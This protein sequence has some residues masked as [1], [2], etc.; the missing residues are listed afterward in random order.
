MVPTS[1]GFEILAEMRKEMRKLENTLLTRVGVGRIRYA[2][3]FGAM[4]FSRFTSKASEIRANADWCAKADEWAQ[5]E[6][7]R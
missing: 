5:A 7:V 6:G 3:R 1:P 4:P 2:E